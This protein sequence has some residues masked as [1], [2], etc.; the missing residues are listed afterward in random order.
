[1]YLSW[2]IFITI[3][4]SLFI[5][6][7]LAVRS[8]KRRKVHWLFFILTFILAI[9][10]IFNFIENETVFGFALNKLFL[11]LDFFL[12]PFLIYLFLIFALNFPK[13]R[14]GYLLEI[15]LIVPAIIVSYLSYF[16][17]SIIYNV[18]IVGDIITFNFG[19]FYIFDLIYTIVYFFAG[20]IKWVFDYKKFTG[21]RKLQTLYVLLG[22]LLSAGFAIITNLILQNFISKGFFRL[23]VYG[24]A[25]FIG[26]TA[27]AIIRYR[28]MNI[29]IL[30]VRS[31]FFIFFVSAISGLYIA[32][33]F[34]I[35]FILDGLFSIQSFVWEVILTSILLAFLFKPL[36]DAFDRLAEKVIYIK[37][38]RPEDL[39]N[40]V[41]KCVQGV[42]K[43]EDILKCFINHVQEVF[44]CEKM[45]ALILDNK[46]NF[47]LEKIGDFNFNFNKVFKNDTK[48]EKYLKKFKSSQDI[49]SLDIIRMEIE[50]GL[51]I[52]ANFN[53]MTKKLEKSDISLVIP[54]CSNERCF[55]FVFMG[56]KKSGDAYT[57]EDVKTL[58]IVADQTA[59][60]LENSLLYYVLKQEKEK[61]ER[62]L[63]LTI[64]RELRMKQ[65]KE[66][67]KQLKK[68]KNI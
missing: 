68:Q 46:K 10:L 28:L 47:I 27:Y 14:K 5:I 49:I 15:A 21:I 39:L 64:G 51:S 59:N 55:G 44:E 30:L 22:S 18:K 65:L 19:C 48:L 50:D 57:Y 53:G 41:H 8:Q 17:N 13:Q 26:F 2:S 38:Y 45:A 63:K 62:T 37:K 32:L 9:W 54:L 12:G 36:E 40:N 3:I 35:N 52:R 43:I 29:K 31:L 16:T 58:E 6:S 24:F 4:F 11:K 67:I 33:F 20:I 7:F 42:L 66:E 1:M 61:V 23:G 25:I 34:L 60:S 56:N